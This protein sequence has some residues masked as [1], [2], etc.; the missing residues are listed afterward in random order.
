MDFEAERACFRKACSQVLGREPLR[1]GIGTLSEKSLHAVLKRYLE[2][3]GEN[4]EIKIAGYV[5][6]IVC[7]TGIIEIQT[8]NFNKIRTKLQRFLEYASVTLVYP[9]PG[10]KWLSWIDPETGEV[11]KRRRSPKIGTPFEVFSELYKIKTLLGHA[12]LKV[13]VLVL[14]LEEYRRLDGWSTDRKK[15][16][17]RVER[18]PLE[19]ERK[20][21]LETAMDYADLL[22]ETLGNPFTTRDFAKETRLTLKRAQTAV[23]VMYSLGALRKVGK[24]GNKILYEVNR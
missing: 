23:H 13:L 15:G 11:T 7:E 19:L 16:S 24:Q 1:H 21:W 10:T 14:E 12:N 8:A 6:D 20:V 2:P 5:A 18:I 22:P 4:H 3:I 9:V 17:S